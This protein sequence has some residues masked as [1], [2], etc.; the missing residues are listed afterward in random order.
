MFKIRQIEYIPKKPTQVKVLFEDDSSYTLN[1]NTVAKFS[2]Y[3]GREIDEQEFKEILKDSFT[4]LLQE[5][6]VGYISYS[7]R[8]EKQVRIYLDK[9]CKK[10]NLENFDIDLII[11]KLKDFKYLNDEAFAELFVR[12]RIK[13]KPR[14]KYVLKSELLSKGI[15]KEIAEK[16]LEDINLDD[17][18]ILKELYLKKFGESIIKFDDKKKIAFLQRKGFSW[19]KISQLIKSFEEN[20]T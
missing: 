10:Y 13:N 12:S 6:A 18:E 16:T 15:D 1:L 5:R 20:D 14:S 4:K 2:L 9:Y 19:E 11:K 17:Y 7:P 3:E 8:T